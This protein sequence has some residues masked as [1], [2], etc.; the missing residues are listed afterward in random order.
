MNAAENYINMFLTEARELLIK[1]NCSDSD[2]QEFVAKYSDVINMQIG[3]QIQRDAI[4]GPIGTKIGP[5]AIIQATYMIQ[6][7]NLRGRSLK[8]LYDPL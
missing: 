2:V 4:D 1:E 5:L 8:S 6:Y 7:R 3:I